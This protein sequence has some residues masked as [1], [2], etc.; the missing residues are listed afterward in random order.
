MKKLS[1][2]SKGDIVLLGL[3]CLLYTVIILCCL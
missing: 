1:K 3:G 2:I